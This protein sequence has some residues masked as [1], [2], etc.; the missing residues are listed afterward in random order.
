MERLAID[1]LVASLG[2]EPTSAAASEREALY[3]QLDVLLR[4]EDVEVARAAATA[5]CTPLVEVVLAAD[6]SAVG[7]A[8]FQRVML[9]LN[10]SYALEPLGIGVDY[11]RNG[12][13]RAPVIWGSAGNA[14]S[15]AASRDPAELC[16]MDAQT[17]AF[18]HVNDALF[19][20]TGFDQ[21]SDLAGESW[22]GWPS[23]PW[24]ASYRRDNPIGVQS[25][26][27][28]AYLDR[29][30]QLF[31]EIL[32]DPQNATD[33]ALA[34]VWLSLNWAM[35]GKPALVLTLVDA[36]MVELAI[37]GLSA[38][39]P[40]DWL[41]WRTPAGVL[42]SAI[43]MQ[44]WAY[45][46]TTFPEEMEVDK[47]QLLLDKGFVEIAL[48]A[49]KEFERRGPHK[50]G[51]SCVM[52]VWAPFALIAS[53]DLS[54]ATGTEPI[55]RMLEGMPSA[56]RFVMDNPVSHVR[57]MGM[58]SAA[59]CMRTC[60][61]VFGAREGGCGFEFAQEHI[62]VS[63]NYILTAFSGSL[64]GFNPVLSATFFRF[65]TRLCS[66]LLQRIYCTEILRFKLDGLPPSLHVLTLT[67]RAR[68]YI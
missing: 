50:V 65:L 57:E 63:V 49:T 32:R 52:A 9:L 2:R 55:V 40:A 13:R 4:H 46:V 51:E 28:A 67:G 10:E 18:A 48:T 36:G 22:T 42:A 11:F 15:R 12:K 6:E 16:R 25:E 3:A 47:A 29:L 59:D 31:L 54:A 38:I 43:F 20:A 30:C 19:H 64:A 37:K 56:L 68:R 21:V 45:S 5:C 24:M 66:Y 35:A 58:V 44:A 26:A 39:S 34:S 53:F 41:S 17:I 62:D 1:A 27:G 8:E 61:L 33:R 60:A 14:Y 23:S 7:A